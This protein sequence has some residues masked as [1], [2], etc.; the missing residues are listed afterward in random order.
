MEPEY[1]RITSAQLEPRSPTQ[2]SIKSH[3]T[4]SNPLGIIL[5]LLIILL[6]FLSF[7]KTPIN[8]YYA[9]NLFGVYGEFTCRFAFGPS[10]KYTKIP[11]AD[12]STFKVL[13]HPSSDIGFEYSTYALDKHNVYL[14]GRIVPGAEPSS[15]K[16]L[17][18]KYASDVNWDY[19]EELDETIGE[20]KIFR[21]HLIK[22]AKTST[23]KSV[24]GVRGG[25]D[26][27]VF[28]DKLVY[29]G[30]LIT[31]L[32][33]ATFTKFNESYFQDKDNVVWTA[34]GETEPL[35]VKKDPQ[36]TFKEVDGQSWTIK[37]NVKVVDSGRVLE[38]ADPHT[39]SSLHLKNGT[40]IQ[41]LSKDKN[42]VYFRWNLVPGADAETFN[43]VSCSPEYYKD[44]N[45]VYYQTSARL[46]I[47]NNIDPY[48]FRSDGSVNGKLADKNG[49]YSN[50][51]GTLTFINADS[52]GFEA[53]KCDW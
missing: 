27:L 8:N 11:G 39:Y 48:T 32:D 52:S 49:I 37:D 3:K 15:F 17:G 45:N 7:K 51:D 20:N 28:S 38:N 42:H 2:S 35:L 4:L 16:L 13:T 33:P 14:E 5:V 43:Y 6:A 46:V 10:C 30:Q 31:Y 25:G 36:S 29:K 18:G 47:L 12:R 24:A 23:G 44:K 21:K 40:I 41:G 34:Y 26:W 53:K 22:V 50:L 9:K 19:Y 1:N